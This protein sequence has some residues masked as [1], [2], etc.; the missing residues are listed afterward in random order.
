MYIFTEQE[1]GQRSRYSDCLDD[2]G[3]RVLSRGRVKNFFFSTLS[4]LAVWPMQ[5]PIQWV[6]GALSLVVK[7]LGLEADHSP[8]ASAE[9][10]ETRIYTATSPY[11]FM[12]LCLI[13]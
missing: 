9:V 5:T 6:P 10:K 12:A 4:R 7:W 2:L 3:F 13:S 8:P 11:V 1:L